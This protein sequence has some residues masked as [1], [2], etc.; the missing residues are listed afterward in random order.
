MGSV[1]RLGDFSMIR[2]FLLM[3]FFKG[4]Q[5]NPRFIFDT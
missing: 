4:I 3:G 1:D 2:G 5:G